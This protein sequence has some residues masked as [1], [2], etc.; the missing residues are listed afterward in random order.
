MLKIFVDNPFPVVLIKQATA[1]RC[2]DLN[3]TRKRLAVVDEESNLLVYDVSGMTS[4]SQT[5][6][7]LELLCLYNKVH[8]WSPH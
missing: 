4:S 6:K 7:A 2:L 5:L 1:V 8:Q 3:C